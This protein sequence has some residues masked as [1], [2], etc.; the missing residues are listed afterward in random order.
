MKRPLFSQSPLSRSERLRNWTSALGV[1]HHRQ[2]EFAAGSL[3][4]LLEKVR[5]AGAKKGFEETAE[6][7]S[8]ASSTIFGGRASLV[9]EASYEMRWAGRLI[10]SFSIRCLKVFG[11]KPRVLAAPFEP[12][13]TP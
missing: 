6:D 12:S 11:C 8:I 13:M 1:P 5:R 2:T 4:E 3:I 9:V 10:P 7:F